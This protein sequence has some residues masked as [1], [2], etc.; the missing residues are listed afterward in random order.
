MKAKSLGTLLIILSLISSVFTYFP[1]IK[2]FLYSEASYITPN[3]TNLYVEI[4]KINA[5]S[6]VLLNIDPTNKLEYETALES[7]IAHAKNT[8]LPGDG[9]S[10][11]FAHSSLPPWKMTRVNTPFLR[12]GE[13]EKGDAIKV[14]KY[15]EILNFVVDE[16]KVVYPHEVQKVYDTKEDNLILM[17]CTPVGTSFR[18]LLVFA[19]KV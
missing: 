19:I 9:L 11:I 2:I 6:Q 5:F 15:G 18:R 13:L 10:F 14:Y 16:K 1:F 8:N 17:T 4:P 3:N 7:G 12:L